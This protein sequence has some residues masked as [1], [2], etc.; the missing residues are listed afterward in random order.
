MVFPKKLYRN[1]KVNACSPDGDT[2]FFVIVAGVLQG[3]TL[4]PYLFIICLHYVLRMSLDLIKENSFTLKTRSKRYSAEIITDLNYADDLRY[5]ANAPAQAESLLYSLKRAAGGIGLHL[6]TNK[7]EY[8]CFN[9]EGTISTLNGGHLKLIDK[10]TY[11]GCSISS[12]ERDVNMC[13]AKAWTAIDWLSIIWKS[14]LSDKIK[15][16]SSK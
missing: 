16:F 8:M 2:N 11:L 4:A 6:N 13:L 3:D 9:Q 1:T 14:D 7:M 10:F 15:R 5:L 12:T